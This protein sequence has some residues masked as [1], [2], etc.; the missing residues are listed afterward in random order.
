MCSGMSESGLQRESAIDA[1]PALAV[2]VYV[3]FENERLVVSPECK[4][5]YGSVRPLRTVRPRRRERCLLRRDTEALR[6]IR[7][8][9]EVRSYERARR[10]PTV[11]VRRGVQPLGLRVLPVKVVDDIR[12]VGVEHQ[13]V[14]RP[15]VGGGAHR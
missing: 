13:R 10:A 9:G 11:L 6:D 15:V 3:E 5:L 7:A 12:R 4:F 2:D 14:V 1:E 8:G